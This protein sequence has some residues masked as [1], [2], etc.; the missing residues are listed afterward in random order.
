MKT[1]D[2]ITNQ[3]HKITKPV[4]PRHPDPMVIDSSLRSSC[5]KIKSTRC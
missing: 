4:T 3:T 5:S 2:Q 1:L